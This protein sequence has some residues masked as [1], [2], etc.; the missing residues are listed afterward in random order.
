VRFRPALILPGILMAA[1]GVG[2]G[3]LLTASLAGS[4]IGVGIAW[5]A[6]IGALLK[7]TL[8]EGIAR[9]QMATG[10]TMLEGWVHRLGA[11]VQWVFI[12]YLIIWSFSVGGALVTAC[13]VAGT[14][15][16]PLGDPATSKIVWGILHSL[17][18]L[19]LV[20]IGGFRVF[21]VLMSACIG[22]MFVTVLLTALLLG[23]DW[24]ALARGLF[25]PAIPAGG[26]GWTL[27]VLGG[28]G[29]TVT[30]LSYGYWIRETGRTGREGVTSCRVDLA[31]GYTVTALFGVA[32]VIIGSR[33]ALDGRGASLALILSS[34]LELA[35]GAPGKW[36][37]LLGFWGAVFSSLLGVWQSDPYMFANFLAL[38]KGVS[39]EAFQKSDITRSTPYRAYLVGL[40]IVPLVLL[41]GSVA[42]VQ[43]T[44]A[45]LG[46]FFLPLVAL[47]LLLM[48]N[49]TDWV[50]PG[51]KSHPVINAVLITT[52]LFFGYTG[53]KKILATL[54]PILGG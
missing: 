2:A 7:W 14:G 15:L 51:F 5:A 39:P 17:V 9:W 1:T 31:V 3:D 32:M 25:F 29:G 47:T 22:L 50:G 35:L 34:Q 18:G 21:E 40:A 12:V 38:R 48:N 53:V 42:E 16:L 27:G 41:W 8:N 28:V 11:W 30:L 10:T 52:L 33:V 43:L 36:A 20:W 49:R 13:G 6:V 4:R 26:V 46:S 45:V 54:G 23:P 24:N 19:A 44:Y 37:F